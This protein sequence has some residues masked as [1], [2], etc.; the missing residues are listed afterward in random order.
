MHEKVNDA[1]DKVM[2]ICIENLIF[3][4]VIGRLRSLT[5]LFEHYLYNIRH[6]I[7]L[8]IHFC[9]KKV[10]FCHLRYFL[11][12]YHK[13]NIFSFS[14]TSVSLKFIDI[15][16]VIS[17]HVIHAKASLCKYC[18]T[19]LLYQSKQYKSLHGKNVNSFLG[20]LRHLLNFCVVC[21]RI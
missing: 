5:L 18:L 6:V 19:H 15:R 1:N 9:L 20:V 3:S 2:L 4:W 17:A 7:I 10:H 8:L 11:N 16:Y 14:Q 12:I 21:K 13:Y